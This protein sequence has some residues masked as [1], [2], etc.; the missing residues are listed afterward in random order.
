MSTR[1]FENGKSGDNRRIV[2]ASAL[3]VLLLFGQTAPLLANPTGGAVVAG[4]AT[5]GAAGNT[6]SINQ[7]SNQAIINWQTFS[8]ANGETTRFFVPNSNSSTLNFVA[9]GNP[10]AIYGTL[11]SN[12]HLFLINP[13]GILVGSTGRIDTAGFVGSTLNPNSSG[14]GTIVF[15]GD[16]DASV[17]NLGTISASSGNVY[18]IANEVTNKGSLNA[19]Q[20][21]VGLAA[22]SNVLL[23]QQGDEHLFV[24]AGPAT[25]HATGVTNS[26]SIKAA[27]AELKAAGGNAYALAINNSGSI[28]ATGFK[29]VNGQVY[30]TADTGVISNSGSI[31]ATG[32]SH[33]GK[34]RLTSQSGT[35]N[36][37][38]TLD[39]SATGA[40]GKGGSVLLKSAQG[41]VSNT[42]VINAKGGQGGAGGDVEVSGAVVDVGSGVVNTLAAGGQTGMFTIDPAT[43]TVAASG[44]DE[45]GAQ[46][47]TSLA[48]TD[49]TLNADTA[50]TINDSITWISGTTLTLSTNISGSTIAINAA[51]SGGGLT[52]N[53]AGASD[54]VTTSDAGSIN[55]AA[56][57]LQNGTWQQIVGQN[58]L[59]A[60]PAFTASVDFELQNGST[61]E[62]F[63]GGDGSI[64]TPFQITDVYGL[65]GAGSPSG[66]LL[67]DSFVL[68]NDID[69]TSTS[70]WNGGAGFTPIGNAT[71]PFSGSLEGNDHTINGLTVNLPTG[72]AGL[73]GD[74]SVSSTISDVNLTADSITGKNAGGIAAFNL[75]YVESSSAAGT[76]S[77]AATSI[78][79][80]GLVGL[81]E[82]IVFASSS[83][84]TVAGGAN[85]GADGGL[86]GSNPGTVEL[87]FS[88]AY[89]TGSNDV[90]GLV[91]FN[92]TTGLIDDSFSSG[93]VNGTISA[94]GLVGFN[95]GTIEAS[96]TTSAVGGSG[97]VGGLVGKNGSTGTVTASYWAT[98]SGSNQQE[99]LSTFGLN[100]GTTDSYTSGQTLAALADQSTFLPVGTGPG[101]WDFATTWTT[102]GNTTTPQLLLGNANTGGGG[103]DNGG[104]PPVNLIDLASQEDGS[105]SNLVPV[106][107]V[108]QNPN[109]NSSDAGQNGN[110][111][112]VIGNNDG[113][114]GNGGLAD[115]SG[116]GG[117]IG[118][119][120]AG[121][122]GGGALG[123]FSDPAVYS[124]FGNA[125][126]AQVYIS[127][128]G[129][130][131]LDNGGY[132]PGDTK[133]GG[134]TSTVGAGDVIVIESGKIHN[135]AP[136]DVPGPLKNALGN[137]AF[138]N[139][140]GH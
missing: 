26:G 115:S 105:G 51:I 139:M 120:D 98:D 5:I 18:L 29:K 97:N 75:G 96:Y 47:A 1:C 45:T 90:G 50:I 113:G 55:V 118:P 132:Y 129:A 133:P 64:V 81:N 86:V 70:G 88:S 42:G 123:N 130:L 138:N 60:L 114:N 7:A 108:P 82:G 12:G 44:G 40:G 53:T 134:D 43:L 74:T 136:G 102:N 78:D 67:A 19:P 22:G 109:V 61:F 126:G 10:S 6:L 125:L 65:Q 121:V 83:S 56:F 13:S 87:S 137:G 52:I 57:T 69:A 71:T 72:D 31:R 79:V 17:T 116:N 140:P 66:N 48:T 117:L 92:Y 127:L 63:A 101:Q 62:R 20:G 77:G 112:G 37:T 103:G 41:L 2:G 128:S 49:I 21:T 54:L 33:G 131:G 119:G 24:Q 73:F 89:V 27:T 8:I 30:L 107:T 35:I 25:Q 68:N 135:V 124:A 46:V 94:G 95:A 106:S 104:T 3:S 4:S 80:G 28:A 15:S 11:S 91:G 93:P 34:I 99:G 122:L 32:T 59:T 38:G 23:Q 84:G 110:D 58:G 76:V 39:A 85:S 111:G 36:N 14:N 100:R 9:A 16:S